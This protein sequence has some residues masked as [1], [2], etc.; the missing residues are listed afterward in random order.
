MH[1]P[2]QSTTAMMYTAPGQPVAFTV[3]SRVYE[4]YD[5]RQ[6]VPCGV[7]LIIIGVLSV[8]LEGGAIGGDVIPSYIGHGICCGVLVGK[9]CWKLCLCQTVNLV[10]RLSLQ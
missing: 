2:Q 7:T 4:S 9:I 6:S 8:A 3:P 1:Q 10:F 5:S